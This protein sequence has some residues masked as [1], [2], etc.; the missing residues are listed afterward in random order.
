LIFFKMF[1]VRFPTAA[2]STKSFFRNVPGSIPNCGTG[3]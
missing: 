3:G 1:L 2:E